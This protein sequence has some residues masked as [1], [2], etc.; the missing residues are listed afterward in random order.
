[1]AKRARRASLWSGYV[2]QVAHHGSARPR[3]DEERGLPAK[4]PSPRRI[5][6]LIESSEALAA[7]Q[8]QNV[9]ELLTE[10]GTRYPLRMPL[11]LA[12]RVIGGASRIYFPRL[13]ALPSLAG[14]GDDDK[15]AVHRFTAAFHGLVQ[16][17][18]M[19]PPHVQNDE[20]VKIN[21][22]LDHLVDW[23]RYREMNP[24]E[25]PLW[26]QVK[27]VLPDASVRVLWVVGPNVERNQESVLKPQD[28]CLALRQISPTHWF[29]GAGKVYP[30]GI[31]WTRQPVEVPD[32]ADRR[33]IRAAWDVIPRRVA[34]EADA[35]P[36]RAEEN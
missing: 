12:R 8:P 3:P 14:E 23:D 20:D 34:S 2:L 35:W 32:P 25:Q 6:E 10:D 19:K 4:K 21:A 5:F 9:V 30:S 28:V 1:M 7:V 33:A 24:I 15:S 36:Q 26:G 11:M 16:T 31:Q 22:V 13:G 18:W 29:Y 17:H 27:S